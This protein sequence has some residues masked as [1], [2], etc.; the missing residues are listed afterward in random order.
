MTYPQLGSGV[1][2]P[3]WDSESGARRATK[4]ERKIIIWQKRREGAREIQAARFAA[5]S[6]T[7]GAGHEHDWSRAWSFAFHSGPTPGPTK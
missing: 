3:G 1:G 5:S 2:H 7:Y 4:A 6:Y